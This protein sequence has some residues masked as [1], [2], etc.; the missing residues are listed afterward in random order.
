MGRLTISRFTVAIALG[1]GSVSVALS[2]VLC[3][4]STS[5]SK[6]SSHLSC[7]ATNDRI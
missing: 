2:N 3:T 4:F 7:L 6:S 1:L 5:R